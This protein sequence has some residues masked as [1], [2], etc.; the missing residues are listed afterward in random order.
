[1]EGDIPV[2]GRWKPGD[3]ADHIGIFRNGTWVVDSNGDDLYQRS[4]DTYIFGSAGDVPIVSHTRGN[5]GVFRRGVWILDI[6]GNHSWDP[7]DASIP[8]AIPGD[9]PVI[10]EW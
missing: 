5:I 4:D 6:N 1:M 8:A 7:N 9:Q 2:V 10:G 3:R